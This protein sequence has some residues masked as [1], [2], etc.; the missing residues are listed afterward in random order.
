MAY[1]SAMCRMASAA[2]SGFFA[3]SMSNN[4][5]KHAENCPIEACVL[6]DLALG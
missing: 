4:G 2:M 3:L 1:S 6:I 5:G